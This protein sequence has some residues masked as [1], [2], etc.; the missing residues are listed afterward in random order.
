MKARVVAARG[1]SRASSRRAEAP[2]FASGGRWWSGR[3]VLRRIIA[4]LLFAA[5]VAVPASAQVG[6]DREALEAEIDTGLA[7]LDMLLSSGCGERCHC[8]EACEAVRSLRRA[9][10]RLCVLDPGPPCRAARDKLEDAERRVREACPACAVDQSVE[11]RPKEEA[12]TVDDADLDEE[13]APEAIS[14]GPAERSAPLASPP[15]AQGGGCASCTVGHARDLDGA[16]W[17]GLGVAALL[18]RRRRRVVRD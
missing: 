12:R 18:G 1:A 5:C 9:A 11:P 15:E 13:R 8:E 7:A 17:L 6:D 16:L 2:S 3:S 4:P 14:P 10:E